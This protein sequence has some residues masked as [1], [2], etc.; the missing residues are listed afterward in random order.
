MNTYQMI[1]NGIR[2][3]IEKRENRPI[4]IYPFGETGV[5]VK[6]I[7]NW[8]YGLKEAIIVD[9]LLS[10]VNSDIIAWD[11]VED[12][13]KYIWLLTCINPKIHQEILSS[14]KGAAAEGQ[15]VDLYPQKDEKKSG[16]GHL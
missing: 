16:G 14:V 10:E 6:E 7:L 11:N 1:N 5:K 12:K 9:N 8:R 13:D 2:K 3:L 15:V 4:A